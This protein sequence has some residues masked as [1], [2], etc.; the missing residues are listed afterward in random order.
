MVTVATSGGGAVPSPQPQ[1]RARSIALV[2]S[3]AFGD[4]NFP[5]DERQRSNP[6]LLTSEDR[7]LPASF[8]CWKS[9]EEFC[10]AGGGSAGIR[11]IEYPL[12]TGQ[13]RRISG[14]NELWI[15]MIRRPPYNICLSSGVGGSRPFPALFEPVL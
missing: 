8:R 4:T 7:D 14:L 2:R 11:V 13:F 12:G 15:L 3:I 1:P 10:N 9:F 6:R 5:G